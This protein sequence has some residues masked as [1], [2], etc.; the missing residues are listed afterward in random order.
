MGNNVKD[1]KK[2]VALVT[3]LAVFSIVMIL[4]VGL[5]TISVG[6][7]RMA[8]AEDLYQR[9]FYAAESL[10]NYLRSE[11]NSDGMNAT[12]DI[13]KLMVHLQNNKST[14]TNMSNAYVGVASSES[15]SGKDLNSEFG[16]LDVKFYWT[17]KAG[18]NVLNMVVTADYFEEKR[19]LKTEFYVDEP[20]EEEIDPTSWFNYSLATKGQMTYEVNGTSLSGQV[21]FYDSLGGFH[22]NIKNA[23]LGGFDECDDKFK[24]TLTGYGINSPYGDSPISGN[25]QQQRYQALFNYN[26]I[27]SG[28]VIEKNPN[29]SIR[30]ITRYQSGIGYGHTDKEKI[31]ISQNV[32]SISI[33]NWNVTL[34]ANKTD[35]MYYDNTSSTD[36]YSWSKPHVMFDL[37][38]NAVSTGSSTIS[39]MNI[40]AAIPGASNAYKYLTMTYNVKNDGIASTADL[41]FNNKRVTVNNANQANG[42]VLL[43]YI[44]NDYF[45]TGNGQPTSPT[46]RM[47][48]KIDNSSI[49]SN[50]A[51]GLNNGSLIYLI[52]N[53]Y[54]DLEIDS[55][56]MMEY[57]V[58]MPNAKITLNAGKSNYK[59]FNGGYGD[60]VEPFVYANLFGSYI[61]DT[62]HFKLP[63]NNDQS[64]LENR[65][66][67]F[68][69]RPREAVINDFVDPPGNIYSNYKY[70]S[71][72]G[73]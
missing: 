14:Y 67:I 65:Y 26:K 56:S 12:S 69:F 40:G 6:A 60:D 31:Y 47:K 9:S 7:Y 38:K 44:T 20:L 63:Q 53:E 37:P 8:V 62:L 3:V 66:D 5:L 10:S 51:S 28:G 1:G 23:S 59:I 30:V 58:Y 72:K 25:I 55:K 18:K 39:A 46:N 33:P 27:G 50:G 49:Y 22:T 68:Y 57:F 34:P 54:I 70:V 52:S 2:G 42:N 13:G 15:I 32:G 21:G 35:F 41:T 73:E 61:A 45:N 29:A 64:K 43:M 11:I 17:I 4:L 48:I 24:Y 36:V 19:S 16:D 71:M